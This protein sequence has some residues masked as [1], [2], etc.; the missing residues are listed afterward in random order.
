[1]AAPNKVDA[2]LQPHGATVGP[3]SGCRF[4]HTVTQAGK[5]FINHGDWQQSF[6]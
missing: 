6:C 3:T 2:S 5:A 4:H 1:M